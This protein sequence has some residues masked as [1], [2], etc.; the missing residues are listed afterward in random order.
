M[1]WLAEAKKRCDEA[2][3]GPWRTPGG[4]GTLDYL[5][6]T[7][8][9]LSCREG[10]VYGDEIIVNDYETAKKD[11]Q[12]IAHARTDLPKALDMLVRAKSLLMYLSDDDVAEDLDLC[13]DTWLE[14]LGK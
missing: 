6:E 2:T 5:I 12:F 10:Y 7:E 3:P 9:L 13:I 1:S 8:A 14:E 4:D 11:L